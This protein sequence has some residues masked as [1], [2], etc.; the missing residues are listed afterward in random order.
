MSGLKKMTTEE[1]NKWRAEH[2]KLDNELREIRERKARG[3]F[4]HVYDWQTDTKLNR[5]DTEKIKQAL[6]E[7]EGKFFHDKFNRPIHNITIAGLGGAKRHPKPKMT[8]EYS[9]IGEIEFNAFSESFKNYLIECE[10]FPV[11]M[12]GTVYKK[13]SKDKDS[14]LFQLK[15]RFQS[16]RNIRAVSNALNNFHG[17]AVFLTLT[18]DPKKISWF[19]AWTTISKR[20]NEF[21]KTLKRK[22]HVED[23]KYI[24]VL[25][26]QL[27]STYYPHVHMLILNYKRIADWHLIAKWWKWGFIWINSNKEGKKIRN[28]VSY[29]MKY[30]RKGI[31]ALEDYMS[32]SF[33]N[34]VLIWLFN[35]R[36]FNKSN[37]LMQFLHM[38]YIPFINTDILKNYNIFELAPQGGYMKY[39]RKKHNITYQG[40]EFIY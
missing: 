13:S 32:K 3:E 29:M 14:V 9:E 30:I 18:V 1:Y 20:V 8:T 6:H 25:E 38:L 33:N 16:T 21:V 5:C 12:K 23:L 39:W 24:Y 36:Q 40:K 26:T 11:Y 28:P 27:N 17:Q 7:Q 35:K 15:N 19:K 4:Y 34:D 2:E 31:V 10:D 37:F 22:L